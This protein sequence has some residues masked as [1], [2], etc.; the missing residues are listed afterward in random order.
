MKTK[1]KLLGLVKRLAEGVAVGEVA[2][3]SSSEIPSVWN[4]RQV[5][6]QLVYF[7]RDGESQKKLQAVIAREFDLAERIKSGAEHERHLI[8]FSRIDADGL[9]I[10][11]RFTRFSLVDNRNLLHRLEQEPELCDGVFDTLGDS[12]LY[13]GGNVDRP[14]LLKLLEALGDGR[15]DSVEL[16]HTWAREVLVEIGASI[17]D[18]LRLRLEAIARLFSV[19]LW[20]EEND[21][22]SLAETLNELS[23]Q[24]DAALAEKHQEREAKAAANAERATAAR[25]RTN[26]KVAADEA[27]RRMQQSRRPKGETQNPEDVQPE[28]RETRGKP[29]APKRTTAQPAN[30]RSKP[31][32]SDASRRPPSKK[33]TRPSKPSK[34]PKRDWG[35]GDECTLSRG[36]FAGKKGVIVDT[37]SKGYAKVKVGVIEVNVSLLELDL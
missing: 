8:L 15:L 9:T 12:I 10:G 3:S 28:P 36:L 16:S 6:E 17:E 18:Q 14:Q 34:V 19:A 32:V 11:L 35:K 7:S 27:W 1:E 20:T 33:R 2:L 37:P 4:G 25:E 23:Q 21:Q 13:Q 31:S 24:V 30:H 5:K 26:A 22:L 29:K